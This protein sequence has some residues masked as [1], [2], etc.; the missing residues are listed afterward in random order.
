MI[1]RGGLFSKKG[2]VSP[3]A[4]GVSNPPLALVNDENEMSKKRKL[5]SRK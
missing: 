2:L 1:M 5:Q 4:S 3:L